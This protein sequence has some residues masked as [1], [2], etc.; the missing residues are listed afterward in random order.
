MAA[1]A[2]ASIPAQKQPA[3]DM[4]SLW[5][6]ASWG[7]AASLALALA[8]LAGYSETGSRLLATALNG[9]GTGT[10]E[11]PVASRE[12]DNDRAASSQ[13][14]SALAVD[15]NQL[16]ARLS[17][18]E[19]HL[20]DLTGSIK[21]QA[22]S[23]GLVSS[24]PISSGPP[25]PSPTRQAAQPMP[26]ETVST[27]NAPIVARSD[28]VPAAGVTSAEHASSA[29]ESKTQFGVDIGAAANFDG[30]R[31]LWSSTKSSNAAPFEG[32]SPIVGVNESGR[33]RTPELRLIVGPFSDAET[34]V[35]WCTTLAAGNRFCQ[36]SSFEG[37]RLTDADRVIER[38]PPPRTVPRIQPAPRLFGLF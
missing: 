28:S 9:P 6:V 22:A 18:I 38:K 16:D 36:L 25:V 35:R 4:R 5:R 2:R 33:A 17:M 20:D 19:R 31:Q 29:E 3:F 7:T 12:A 1:T 30:L 13:A 8:A 32:L 11:A 24:G 23:Q 37:Q 34:A 27:S 10:Q 14:L 26:P 15:R 21:A